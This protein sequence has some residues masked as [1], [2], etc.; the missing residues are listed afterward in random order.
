MENRD[1]KFLKLQQIID[2]HE[3]KVS[4]LI[5]ILQETQAEYGCLPKEV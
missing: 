1:I 4:H 5:A 2:S 3:G